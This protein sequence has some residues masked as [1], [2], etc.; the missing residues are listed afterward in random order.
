MGYLYG[1][2]A[3]IFKIKKT[4][5]TDCFMISENR[6][7]PPFL[8]Y[9]P[10]WLYCLFLHHLSTEPPR[11]SRTTTAFQPHQILFLEWA[12]CLFIHVVLLLLMQSY[13]ENPATGKVVH[14]LKKK[15]YH[16]AWGKSTFGGSAWDTAHLT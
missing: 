5:T 15:F 12:S 16:L 4:S 13:E 1:S 10:A 7:T 2:K 6:L 11:K 9:A 8:L 3:N 14:L